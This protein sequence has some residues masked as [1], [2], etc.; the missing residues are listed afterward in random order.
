M[1]QD[2]GWYAFSE[3]CLHNAASVS[4]HVSGGMAGDAADEFMIVT[5]ARSFVVVDARDLFLYRRPDPKPEC[6]RQAIRH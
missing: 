5:Q 4:I 2:H 1:I 6:I 3:D